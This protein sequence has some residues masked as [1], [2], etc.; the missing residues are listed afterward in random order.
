MVEQ[1]RRERAL[2][3]RLSDEG[4]VALHFTFQD[5]LSLYMG[6]EFCPNGA[7]RA[8][9]AFVL[10]PPCALCCVRCVVPAFA[11]CAVR[12][13]VLSTAWKSWAVVGGL[14]TAGLRTAGLRVT[15]LRGV[16]WEA[17]QG[18][19]GGARHG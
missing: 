8:A 2:L 10:C 9:P 4:I 3:D 5:A 18:R 12:D 6:L 13:A 7:L 14:H 16:A 11:L 17:A 15:G 1:V 19:E